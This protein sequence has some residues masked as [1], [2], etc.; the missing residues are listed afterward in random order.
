MGNGHEMARGSRCAWTFSNPLRYNPRLPTASTAG[1]NDLFV[2]GGKTIGGM[3][4]I[5]TDLLPAS[6]VAARP[7]AQI[8]RFPERLGIDVASY[9]TPSRRPRRRPSATRLSW[10]PPWS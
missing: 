1:A 4:E 9:D 5:A 3:P 7:V 6:E 2:P 8:R 10:G